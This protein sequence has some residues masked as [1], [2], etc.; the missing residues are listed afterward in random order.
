MQK[1]TQKMQKKLK[2]TKITPRFPPKIY[3]WVKLES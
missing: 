3:F 2:N 1:N